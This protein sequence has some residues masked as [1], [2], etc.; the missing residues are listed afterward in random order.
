MTTA[1]QPRVLKLFRDVAGPTE[2]TRTR[3]IVAEA[4]VFSDGQAVLHW[5][6]YPRGTE[7]YPSEA[8]MRAVREASGRSRFTEAS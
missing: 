2:V 6:G 5:L 8:E 7:V 4:I 3:G 1:T